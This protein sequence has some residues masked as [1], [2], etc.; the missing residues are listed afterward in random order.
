[1][2]GGPC[3]TGHRQ[4]G[5]GGP[6]AQNPGAGERSSVR[7]G[8]APGGRCTCKRH[9]DVAPSPP[10][11]DGAPPGRAPR[12]GPRC[13]ARPRRPHRC[14]ARVLDGRRA[15]PAGGRGADG[16]GGGRQ[17]T[18]CPTRQGG[19][20]IHGVRDNLYEGPGSHGCVNLRHEDA[21]RLWG[22]LRLGDAV[23]VWGRK[24]QA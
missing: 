12:A 21:Q 9:V 2:R 23:Y 5:P 19:Q 10:N 13:P 14:P 15:L 24:P 17:L 4:P 22:V 6:L 3:D 20:A 11:P 1:M 16:A 7:R 8:H 18:S